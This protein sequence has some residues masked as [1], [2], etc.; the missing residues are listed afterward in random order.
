MDAPLQRSAAALPVVLLQAVA[1]WPQAPEESLV[2]PILLVGDNPNLH[3][4]LAR[5]LRDI[6]M[7][8]VSM[9][10]YR[11]GSFGRGGLAS[12][13]LPYPQFVFQPTWDDQWGAS[14]I[15]QA[16]RDFSGGE[17][18]IVFEIQDAS[19]FDWLAHPRPGTGAPNLRTLGARIHA[20]VPVDAVGPDGRLS[21]IQADA[22]R[23]CE[24]VVA[25]TRFGQ[26]VL[27]DTIGHPVKWMPH[28][29]SDVWQPKDRKA[30]RL[31]FGFRP[32]DIVIGCVSTNQPRKQWDVV[33]QCLAALYDRNRNARGWWHVDT[34]VR[35]HAWDIRALLADFGISEIVRVTETGTVTDEELAYGYSAC[36]VTILPSNEGFGYSLVES[37][38]C[39]VPAIHSTYGGG[40]EL[41]PEQWRVAPKGWRYTGLYNSMVPVFDAGDFVLAV[42]R[43]LDD[44][45]AVEYCM[46]QVAHLRWSKLAVQWKK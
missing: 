43:L 32:S 26:R 24:A 27:Q 21:G 23:S 42:E 11:V 1:I 46:E 5:I 12:R 39:G 45:P 2:T 16:W 18:G 8:L 29:I 15:E 28:G 25:Y 31:G 17:P 4:G 6:S 14:L 30:A 38:A 37:M 13:R 3:T 35:A 22:V 19:R 7:V 44:R 33:A 10:E 41:V 36:D 40:A 34:L 20:Y 9:P